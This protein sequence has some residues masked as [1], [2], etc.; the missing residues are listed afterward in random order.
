[1]TAR[2]PSNTIQ[3]TYKVNYTDTVI[4]EDVNTAYDELVALGSTLGLSPTQSGTWGGAAWSEL[5]GGSWPTVK[6]RIQNIENGVYTSIHSRVFTDGGSTIQAANTSTIGLIVKAYA[7]QTVDLFQAQTSAGTIVFKVDKDGIPYYNG[8]VIATLTGTETITNKTLTGATISGASN[9]LSNIPAT[10]VI[11]VGS[12]NIKDY[13][14]GKPTVYY[15]TTAPVS[16][17]KDG[18]VWVDKSSS[19]TV[20]DPTSFISVTSPSV[21]VSTVGFRK[22]AASTAAPTSSD[23]ADGDV[24]LQYIA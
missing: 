3:F 18:D 4:A 6:D 14:D 17:I 15:Q 9:T 19:I 12:T 11:A 7:S 21:S 5:T 24:W 1:M 22:I 13:V 20:F 2:Y 10:A 23:G 16:G 8:K